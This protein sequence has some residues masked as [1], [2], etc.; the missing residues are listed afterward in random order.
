MKPEMSTQGCN[1]K[2]NIDVYEYM[3]E[4][5]NGIRK[6]V[7]LTVKSGDIVNSMTISWGQIGIEWNKLIF[8]AFIRE[9]RYTHELLDESDEFTIN[10]PINREDDKN[11]A[12]TLEYCGTKSGRDVD[13]VK[14]L[15]LTLIEGL[16]VQP[17]AIKELPLTLE[18]KV[19]YKQ[20]QNESH[21]AENIKDRFYTLN[22]SSNYG[23]YH[24]VFYGEIMETY[25]VL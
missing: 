7:L 19:I 22:G 1:M 2:K 21:I 24:T 3:N 25:I 12:R 4:I 23:N 9:D 15:N 14:D 5:I 11:I 10:I 13:K 16:S 18:C 6:G 17:P 8:T 20:A